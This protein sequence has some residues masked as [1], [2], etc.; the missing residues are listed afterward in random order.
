MPITAPRACELAPTTWLLLPLPGAGLNQWDSSWPGTRSSGF[1]A[2]LW[3]P[4]V[5]L[6]LPPGLGL[7]SKSDLFPSA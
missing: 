4:A 7:A 6:S 5:L 1:W 3:A 2:C